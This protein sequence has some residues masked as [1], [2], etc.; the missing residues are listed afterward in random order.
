MVPINNGDGTKLLIQRRA[1]RAAP[2]RIQGPRHITAVSIQKKPDKRDLR[3]IKL[4]TVGSAASPRT[5][6]PL[7]PGVVLPKSSTDN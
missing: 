1:A 4:I 5:K 3:Y 2:G 6:Y 7:M